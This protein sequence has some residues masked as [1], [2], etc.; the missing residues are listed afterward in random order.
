[1]I[2]AHLN[3]WHLL[4]ALSV[5]TRPEPNTRLLNSCRFTRNNFLA[6]LVL[7]LIGNSLAA[8]SDKETQTLAVKTPIERELTAGQSHSYRI[9]L[10]TGQYIHIVVEQRG[11]DVVVALFAPNGSKITEVDSPNGTQGPEFVSAI[12][13]TSGSYRLEVRS[14]EKNA[15]AGRYEVKIEE[16]RTAT[17]KD[18]TRITAQRLFMEA[19]LLRAQGTVESLKA[20]LPKYEE[21]LPFYKAIGDLSGEATTLNNIGYIY[22]TLFEIPKALSFYDRALALAREA[23]DLGGE[24][25]T[26]NN[27][28]LIYST[29]G[30]KKRAFDYFN[31][32]LV[33]V[34]NVG[35]RSAEALTLNNLGLTLDSLGEKQK[36]LDYF[37]QAL[38][39]TRK[40]GD[41]NYEA[42]TLTNIGAVYFSLQ[43]YPTALEYVSKALSI[44]TVT[45]DRY[46]EAVAMSN[47]AAIYSH[48]GKKPE[49]IQYYLTALPI[50]REFGERR[51][52]AQTLNSIGVIYQ[53]LGDNA[54]CLSYF[55][56]ALVA[57]R[58]LEDK[59]GEARV[60]NNI[61]GAYNALGKK[62][63]ALN[64]YGQALTLL[65]EVGDRRG[66]ALTLDNINRIRNA[67]SEKEKA[68]D[69]AQALPVKHSV[70]DVE[71]EAQN[72]YNLMSVYQLLSPRFAIFYGTQSVNLYQQQLSIMQ[73]SDMDAQKSY[74]K[75][76]EHTYR[77]LAE[78]LISEGR[79]TE[80][81]QV[82]N[83]FKDQQIFDFDRT[84]AR[85]PQ[86]LT[87]SPREKDFSVQLETILRQ[88][89]EID[90]RI[91]EVRASP[92]DRSGVSEPPELI[93]LER[94]H[95]DAEGE[96]S[97][98]LTQAETDFSK[99]IDDKDK[100]SDVRDT[101]E[102]QA[103]LR[104]IDQQTGQKTVAVYTLVGQQHFYAVIISAEGT[105][106]VWS[107]ANGNEVNKKARQLWALLQSADYDP[108]TLS[109]ELYKVIFE[110]IEEKLPKD[111]QTIVWSLDENLRYLPMAALYDGKHYLVERYNHVVF[112]RTNKLQLTRP[113]SQ[114]WTGSVFTT[115][116]PHTIILFGKPIEFRSLDFIKDE[117]EIF[118]TKSHANG[119]I[120]ADIL[121]ET[122]FTEASLL[123]RLKQNRPLVHISSH[124][125]FRPGDA[126]NSFLVLG[127]DQVM[128]LAV[129]K[130][131]TN[132]F[133]GVELLTLS[134]CDTAAQRPDSNGREVD[135]FAELAQRLGAG[136]VLAS[137]WA[138]R[139]KST[140]QLMTRFYASREGG[141]R[142]KAEALRQAQMDLL[143]G[144][145]G[146]GA[147][148]QQGNGRPRGATSD[149][150]DVIVEAQ[151]RIPFK[152]DKT[153]PFAHPYYW[154]PFVLF[155][156]WQ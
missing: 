137:L 135:A 85:R 104:E 138:V 153:K 39:L 18:K 136:A 133:Q 99:P 25:T 95:K 66:E 46:G 48:L 51:S 12:A 90:H 6:L 81:Q 97:K 7:L 88:T 43:D 10:Y 32:A 156:N 82:L 67:S 113:V 140:A 117:M 24:A 108:T 5:F 54:K 14:L 78:L 29:L 131:I 102:L 36:A 19:Q 16:L 111:T 125:R 41:R 124:F 49:A 141:K 20:A 100:I 147:A 74:L 127:D 123:A 139:D 143:Y 149:D 53:G 122:Q 26:L 9:L 114:T 28:G 13:E 69:Y 155:G 55:D 101:S 56:Q 52:E 80:A 118:R 60:L 132:L 71:G 148:D 65:R 38:L 86:P 146:T 61:A 40:L 8:Q 21:A 151:Y 50:Y 144:R 11:V 154:S 42:V 152:P 119:V 134:A 37:L 121:S 91:A 73:A 98:L 57:Y 22:E 17:E 35:N 72:L 59:I 63:E 130:E 31:Q 2:R 110:R 30:E 64:S 76:V 115:S 1:M 47:L 62:Q 44:L 150:E 93:K 129:M 94:A 109:H 103:T 84:N 45:G 34:R 33:L 79:T 4:R 105:S 15:P 142:T 58:S 68:V 70:G 23:A 116:A 87:L 89:S 77:G 145:S 96:L 120:D 75:S 106:A 3:L 92:G 107:T 27:I 126:T 128:T 112:T 83:A